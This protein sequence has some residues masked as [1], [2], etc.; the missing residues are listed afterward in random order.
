MTPRRGAT[1]FVLLGMILAACSMD[2]TPSGSPDSDVTTV[3]ATT[4]VEVED[5]SVPT[6]IETTTTTTTIPEVDLQCVTL[7]K[8]QFAN[9]V[10]VDFSLLKLEFTD[11]S[12][13]DLS[14]A[15]LVRANLKQTV[16][17]RTNLTNAD[18]T[19]ANLTGANL[20]GA[21]ITG[22]NF[23]NAIM[24]N[25]VICGIDATTAVG[26]TDKQLADAQMFRDKGNRYCP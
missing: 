8:C 15:S 25:A 3:V 26:I 7:L 23:T 17:I 20:T 24:T 1:Y 19:G 16:L 22:A 9:L 6:T 11:F 5:T 18:L 14:G 13:A 4:V 2:S 21:L 12:V 10:G